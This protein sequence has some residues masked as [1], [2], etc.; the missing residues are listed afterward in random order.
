VAGRSPVAARIWIHRFV[1][2]RNCFGRF[3]VCC[4]FWWYKF[5]HLTIGTYSCVYCL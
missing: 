5:C 1:E 3:C 2:S 4:C